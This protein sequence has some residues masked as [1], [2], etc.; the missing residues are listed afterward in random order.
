MRSSDVIHPRF[1]RLTHWINAVATIVLI[2]SGLQIH[3]AD[4]IL[5][6]QLPSWMTLGGW[7]GGALL[8][9]FAAMWLLAANALAY[10]LYGLVSGRLRRKLLPLSPRSLLR[11]IR[12]ALHGRLSHGDLAEYNA[13]Q[14]FSYVF[15]ISLTWLAVASGLAMWKPVQLEFLSALFGGFDASRV[16]HFAAMAGIVAFLLVHVVMT[17]LVPRTLLA[18]LRGR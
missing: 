1:V 14:K 13:V 2:M 8:W 18:M 17:L 6:F 9:H 12:A 16:V 7:L 10:L 15:V 3:N 4:P 11:D 5:P